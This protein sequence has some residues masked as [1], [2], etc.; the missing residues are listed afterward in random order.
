MSDWKWRD[1]F[2][3]VIEHRSWQP[4]S[5]QP[6]AHKHPCLTSNPM[7]TKECRP[8]VSLWSYEFLGDAR[9]G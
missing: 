8:H 7:L 4:N 5:R 2:V 3:I 6:R 1:L 9:Y